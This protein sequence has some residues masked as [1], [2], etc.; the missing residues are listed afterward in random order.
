MQRHGGADRNEIGGAVGGQHLIG[1]Q[2][3]RFNKP[4]AQLRQEV[5]RSAQH[6]DF[7][8]NR[9]PLRQTADRLV[10]DCLQDRCSNICFGDSLVQQRL[11]VGFGEHAAT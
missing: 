2:I 7:A 1:G 5:Q 8:A 9:P 6:R 10:D 11:H 4:A 3:Q